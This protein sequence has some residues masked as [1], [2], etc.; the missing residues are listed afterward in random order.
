MDEKI[1]TGAARF[2]EIGRRI[3]EIPSPETVTLEIP[4]PS[5]A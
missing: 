1:A 3:R 5:T 4:V 2:D